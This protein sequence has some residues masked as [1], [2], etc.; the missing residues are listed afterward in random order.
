MLR[1]RE[2]AR[3]ALRRDGP[4]LRP[5]ARGRPGDRRFRGAGARPARRPASA[6]AAYLG[7]SP[8]HM[9]FPRD[10]ERAS[11]YYPSD[12]RFLDPI[13]IDVFDAGLPRD[14]AA[15]SGARRRSRPRPRRRRRRASSTIR[16]SGGSSAPRSKRCTPPSPA[17]AAAQPGD[18]LVADYRAFVAHGGEA[19]RRFAA[20]Q[21][22][23]A[24]EEGENWRAW[25]DA[26]RDGDPEA[27]AAAVDKDAGGLRFRAVLPV[28]RRPAT[29]PRG[30]AGAQERARDRLLSRS[31]GRLRPRRR[32]SLGAGDGADARRDGRRAARPVLASRARTGACPRRIRSPAR[33]RAGGTSARSTPPTCGTPA[34]CASTT[35]WACSASSSSRTARSPAEGAYLSYPL[36]DLIGHI[37]L[38]SQRARCM[39]VGE[40][41]GT[42]AGGI[43]RAA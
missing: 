31:R 32:R 15:R 9:L 2:R 23:A 42:V 13:L 5:A 11:P 17:L 22:I 39:V 24:G 4:A 43:P 21:A 26:L 28:A 1:R 37:A 38:E 12:R 33:G 36:D 40:D 18:T 27:V 41:L 10:R 14:A 20:F 30:G 3:Q 19:L 29:R 8:M 6:G 34:C 35:P 25:P 16:R 7:V